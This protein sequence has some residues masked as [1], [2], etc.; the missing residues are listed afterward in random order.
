M[1][2]IYQKQLLNKIIEIALQICLLIYLFFIPIEFHSA[3]FLSIS[4]CSSIILLVFKYNLDNK[5]KIDHTSLI[6]PF[7]LF[8]LW[9]LSSLIWSILP[10]VT[11]KYVRRE[12]LTYLILYYVVRHS[13]DTENKIKRVITVFFS[14]ALFVQVYGIFAFFKGYAVFNGRLIATFFHPNVFG[15]FAAAS[16][17]FSMCYLIDFKN[18]YKE[19]ILPLLVFISGLVSL[20]FSSSRANML[21]LVIAFLI[22]AIIKEKKLI[23]IFVILL[24]FSVILSPLQ[25]ED[26]IMFRITQLIYMFDIEKSPLGERFYMWNSAMQIIKD[27][28]FTGIGYGKVFREEYVTRI[29]EEAVE[30]RQPHSHNILLEIALETGLPGL[31]L[32]LWLH[33][34]IL[35]YLLNAFKNSKNEFYNKFLLGY[36]LFLIAFFMNGMVDFISRFRLGLLFWFLSSIMVLISKKCHNKQS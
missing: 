12:I 10:G 28:P 3:G 17:S 30:N 25:R 36:S 5:F 4:I 26:L 11:F 6:I 19:K 15:L 21:G 31:F 14:S 24:I 22:M 23:F 20:V 1:E 29:P 2:M 27:N 7:T 32:F 13:F 34:L 18:N 8:F 16:L 35:K 9:S 33:L